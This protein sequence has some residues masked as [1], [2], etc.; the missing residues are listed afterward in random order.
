ME[1]LIKHKF[2]NSVLF[3]ALFVPLGFFLL[4]DTIAAITGIMFESI[5]GKESLLYQINDDIARLIIVGLLMLIM[6][7]F[8]RGKCNFGF[9]GGKLK[10]GILLA[11]PELI[12]PLW[13]FLQI[14]IYD[15]PSDIQYQI[16]E[17][18][19]ELTISL[20]HTA[21]ASYNVKSSDPE[22]FVLK[23]RQENGD[24]YLF[25]FDHNGASTEKVK[26]T[27]GLRFGDMSTSIKNYSVSVSFKDDGSIST[28]GG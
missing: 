5:G 21:G 24:T 14:K 9:R 3:T 10:L 25:V 1:K 4:R 11:L 19:K 20:P 15:A 28:V 22:S 23:E 2:L 27:F 13:N 18:G 7:I 17:N 6:P 16:S 12:V 26:I 8:F